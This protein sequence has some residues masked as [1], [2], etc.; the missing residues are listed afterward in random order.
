MKPDPKTI[1]EAAQRIGIKTEELAAVLDQGTAV[2]Y[3]A[4]DFLFHESMPR[5]WL[6]LVLEGEL[7]LVRG[8]NGNSVLIGLAQPGALVS[9]GVMLDDS[10][11]G[12]SAVTHQGAT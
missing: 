9:E 1:A 12:T 4:G 7:D 6:G 2:T 5:D 11:H 10:P 3:G 8:H